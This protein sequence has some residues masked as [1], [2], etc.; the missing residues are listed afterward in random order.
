MILSHNRFQVKSPAGSKNVP[1]RQLADVFLATVRTDRHNFTEKG[2][3]IMFNPHLSQREKEINRQE[4]LAYAE[5]D[6]LARLAKGHR[7]S[8]RW[9]LSRV[10]AA[11]FDRFKTF[12]AG[13]RHAGR[14]ERSTQR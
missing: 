14:L 8:Q 13:L 3:T 4:A 11:V 1:V 2:A 9:H 10:A 6:R 7:R 12:L 5:R